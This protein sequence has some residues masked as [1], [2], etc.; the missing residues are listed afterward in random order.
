MGVAARRH[1][2]VEWRRRPAP[3]TREPIVSNR[4]TVPSCTRARRIRPRCHAQRPSRL[5]RRPL[6]TSALATRDVGR[7]PWALAHSTARSTDCTASP[8]VPTGHRDSP[9]GPLPPRS[10]AGQM[11][12][13]RRCMTA[14]RAS[15]PRA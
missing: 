15:A 4:A 12:L 5:Q 11:E 8:L 1:R 9:A 7:S 3:T 14:R 2:I 13:E 10:K 6:T